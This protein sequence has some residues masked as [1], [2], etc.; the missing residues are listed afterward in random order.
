MKS[1]RKAQ[2]KTRRPQPLPPPSPSIL[3]RKFSDTRLIEFPDVQGKVV[4]KIEISTG[5]EYHGIT[6]YF[7]DKA[8]LSLN[9]DACFLLQPSLGVIREGEVQVLQEWPPI[10]CTTEVE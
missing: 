9:L 10:R 4:E 8:L 3:E 7:R 5:R 6:I 2:Q 1:K